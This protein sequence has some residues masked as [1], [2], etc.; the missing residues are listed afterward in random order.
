MPGFFDRMMTNGPETGLTP[1]IGGKVPDTLLYNII[2]IARLYKS[3]SNSV[4]LLFQNSYKTVPITV[5]C[6]RVKASGAHYDRTYRI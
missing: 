5:M 6:G 4:F 3:N 2:G 1:V